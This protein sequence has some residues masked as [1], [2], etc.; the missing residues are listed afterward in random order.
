M[1][2]NECQKCKKTWF[3]RVADPK[4]CPFCQ[5]RYWKQGIDFR[6]DASKPLSFGFKDIK[7]GQRYLHAWKSDK[8]NCARWRAFLRAKALRPEL[9]SRATGQGFEVWLEV[10]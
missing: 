8:E 2:K 10:Y 1:L 6:F 3:P 5:T 7:E 9:R 4:K